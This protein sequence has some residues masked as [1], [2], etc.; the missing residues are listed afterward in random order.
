MKCNFKNKKLCKYPELS[1]RRQL[2]TALRNGNKYI[3]KNISKKDFKLIKKIEKQAQKNLD[4]LNNCSTKK[5]KL[6]KQCESY[7]EKI[8]REQFKDIPKD[9]KDPD[10]YIMGGLPA[11]GK[12]TVLR[13]FVPEKTVAIDNDFYKE[14]LA[15][16]FK[17]PSKKFK[18]IHAGLLHN[19]GDILTTQAIDKAIKQKNNVTLDMTFGSL[20]KGKKLIDR[21]KKAGYDVHYLGTQKYPHITMDHMAKR[22]IKNGRYVPLSYVEG[23]G[24]QISTNSWKARKFADTYRIYDTNDKPKF[25]SKSRKNEKANIRNP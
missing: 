10:L 11:S 21:F 7:H 3:E 14:K 17:S 20:E 4:S 6:R 19:Q 25:V 5:G 16:K 23:K 1:S 8:L 15:E 12:T 24:N 13:K 18:L 2:S 9:P 22:F